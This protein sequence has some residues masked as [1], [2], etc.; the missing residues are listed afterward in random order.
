MGRY[1]NDVLES[2]ICPSCD[3]RKADID[4]QYSFGVYAGVMS[5]DCA[6]R[7]YLGVEPFVVDPS[8]DRGIEVRYTPKSDVGADR[9]ANAIAT[10][11][12]SGSGEQ[13]FRLVVFNSESGPR[14]DVV[15]TTIES[16]FARRNFALQDEQRNDQTPVEILSRERQTPFTFVA[17]S[18]VVRLLM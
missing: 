9:I 16:P 12:L 2:G 5:T 1:L 13:D 15:E 11:A 18:R 8:A 4:E 6:C 3:E 17:D 14:T 7:K 10:H